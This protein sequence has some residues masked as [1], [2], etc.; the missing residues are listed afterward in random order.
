MSGNHHDNSRSPTCCHRR[1]I[2][3]S[4]NLTRTRSDK[5]LDEFGGTLLASHQSKERS[6]VGEWISTPACPSR[7]STDKCGSTDNESRFLLPNSCAFGPPVPRCLRLSAVRRL[8]HGGVRCFLN[9]DGDADADGSFV[10][11]WKEWRHGT[12]E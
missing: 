4:S 5:T 9:D 2:R 7:T 1:N 10:S 6:G 8:A 3:K 12:W 11:C